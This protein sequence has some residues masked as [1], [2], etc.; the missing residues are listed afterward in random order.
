LAEPNDVSLFAGDSPVFVLIHSPLVGPATWLPVA[1]QLR[2]SG[3]STVVPDL[4]RFEGDDAPFWQRHTR[5]V[6]LAMREVPTDRRVILV[7]HSGAGALLPSIGRASRQPVAAYV[8]VDA[9]IPRD[10]QSRIANGPFAAFIRQLYAGGGRY[11]NWTEEDL[12]E[13]IPDAD[14]RQRL[15]ADLRP[16]PIGFW[17]EPI[18]VSASWPDA[19]CAFLR[20]TPNSAYDDAAAEARRRGWPYAELPGGHFHLLVAPVAVA[21]SL[22]ELSRRMGVAG[23]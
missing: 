5:A 21:R 15:L 11:P 3:A 10:G 4:A 13:I 6:V 1:G 19:P 14:Q 2:R 12:R 16:P 17:E 20:F 8:F 18:A 9:G 23:M 7:G 22:L